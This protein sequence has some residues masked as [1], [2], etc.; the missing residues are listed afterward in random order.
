MLSATYLSMSAAQGKVSR[1]N[2]AQK[3]RHMK[4][5]VGDSLPSLY[6]TTTKAGKL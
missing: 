2:E 1:D 5:A 3:K 4:C 6:E